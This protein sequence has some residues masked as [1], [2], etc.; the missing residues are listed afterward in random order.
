MRDYGQQ[1]DLSAGALAFYDDAGEQSYTVRRVKIELGTLPTDWTPAPEDA[2][3]QVDNA[4]VRIDPT[5]VTMRGGA[6]RFQAGSAFEVQSGGTF[7]VF[8]ADDSS[9][10]IFGGTAQS[11]H[12]SLGAGGTVK[13][14]GSS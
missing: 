1:A 2:V 12:F 8:A 10:I 6:M 9:Q 5:G 4:S 3:S 14:S 11:P 7:N 13:S